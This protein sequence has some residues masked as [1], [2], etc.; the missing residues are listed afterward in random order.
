[1]ITDKNKYI[2]LSTGAVVN[3]NRVEEFLY[4]YFKNENNYI[5]NGE[6]IVALDSC[7][8]KIKEIPNSV[9]VYSNNKTIKD[10]TTNLQKNLFADCK[11]K[12][13]NIL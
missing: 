11:E 6:I 3:K 10:F 4:F 1:M 5:S 8:Y 13:N 12:I 2:T 9:N 7:G